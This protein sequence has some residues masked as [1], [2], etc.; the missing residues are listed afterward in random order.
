MP[1]VPPEMT[2]RAR[3]LRG[4]AT[5]AERLV[6]LR[7]RTYRPRFT[8]QLVVGR[9]IL[10]LACRQA[11][12]AVEFDGSQHLDSSYDAERTAFLESVGW[13]VMRFWNSE[14]V[15]NPDGVAEAILGEVV[16]SCRPTHPQPLPSREGRKK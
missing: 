5:E 2:R 9:Y 13:R 15:A 8:R 4:N 16:R 6:W 11:R 3:A 1:R 12:L 14:V 10:D 7:L